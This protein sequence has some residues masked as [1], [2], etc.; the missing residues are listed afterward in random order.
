MKKQ[1]CVFDLCQILIWF[2]TLIS[3][4]MCRFLV[5]WIDLDFNLQL[6]YLLI[7]SHKAQINDMFQNSMNQHR[8]KAGIMCHISF[9]GIPSFLNNFDNPWVWFMKPGTISWL[10][11]PFLVRFFL[12]GRR[13]YAK[14]PSYNDKYI[15][16]CQEYGLLKTLTIACS[17]DFYWKF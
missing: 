6:N 9:T 3:L 2:I 8:R 1:W 7:S 12:A 13:D 11:Y 4:A 10:Q 16:C 15:A 5:F 14:D 17:C